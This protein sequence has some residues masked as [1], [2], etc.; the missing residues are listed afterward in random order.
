MTGSALSK[1]AFALFSSS[2]EYDVLFIASLMS[3]YYYSIEEETG[4]ALDSLKN[5]AKFVKQN[6]IR[7][8]YDEFR[9]FLNALKK[10]H[11]KEF[12]YLNG[13][14]EYEKSKAT[15]KKIAEENNI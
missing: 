6:D 14:K 8:A 3:F 15:I 11:D 12:A 1:R 9:E 13:N 7:W 10:I 4:V 2:K 5:A